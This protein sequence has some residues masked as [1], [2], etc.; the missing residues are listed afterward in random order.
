MDISIIAVILL[1]LASFSAGFIDSIAGGGG[2]IMIPSYL[3][4]GL[5]PHFALGTNK[6]VATFGTSAAVTNFIRKGKI[7]IKILLFGVDFEKY[8]HHYKA[9]LSWTLSF[10]T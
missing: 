2:L 9:T 4:A 10:R 3:L 5:P 7:S 6:F 1:T 8:R